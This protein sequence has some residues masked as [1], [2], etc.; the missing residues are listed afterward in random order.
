MKRI[1][2]IAVILALLPVIAGAK[3]TIGK[4]DFVNQ[5]DIQSPPVPGE[6]GVKIKVYDVV[7]EGYKGKKVT[8]VAQIYKD[9]IEKMPIVA[10]PYDVS[11][12]KAYISSFNFEIPNSAIFRYLGKGQHKAMVIINAFVTD[13]FGKTKMIDEVKLILPIEFNFGE[14]MTDIFAM[15][16]EQNMALV[17][18]YAKDVP[19]FA[20][21]AALCSNYGISA[22]I[23]KYTPDGLFTSVAYWKNCGPEDKEKIKKYLKGFL[24]AWK[25]YPVE[26]I[27]KVKL[28]AVAFVKDL[29]Y[30]N[31]LEVG[32][33]AN[34]N[35]GI[36]L[37]N[38]NYS[39][40]YDVSYLTHHEF[41]H[42]IDVVI[43]GP[44]EFN[45]DKKWGALNKPGFMYVGSGL[46]M[47]SSGKSIH[48][49]HPK[50][51]FISVYS[52]SACEED[53]ADVFA[54]LFDH[55]LYGKYTKEILKSDALLKKKFDY[56]KDYLW[57]IS[58]VFDEA[59][60]QN[61]HD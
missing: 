55:Y 12:D 10:N 15:E 52:M 31:S 48:E 57:K 38:I 49:V 41:F 51:G 50:D 16:V 7:I 59:F 14:G 61:L 30:Q 47:I 27:Q 39:D 20:E 29:V 58:P 24:I 56:M 22:L 44:L 17:A 2:V 35:A 4:A 53:K 28:K 19:E 54:Y 45:N 43:T 3:I 33:L 9:T 8:F 5:T 25:E 26:L 1:A 60:F 32:G 13:Q 46:E 18:Q 40:P 6:K 37:M 21:L 11:M 23:D 36:L 42:Y 34:V